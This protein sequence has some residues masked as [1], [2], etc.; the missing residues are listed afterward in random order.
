M[1]QTVILMNMLRSLAT[2]AALSCL[3]LT[4]PAA[5][6][7][8][9]GS[10]Y[11]YTPEWELPL[12]LGVAA[13]AVLLPRLL[14]PARLP[15]PPCGRC[16]PSQ[17]WLGLDRG[18]V[19]NYSPGAALASDV[20][21]VSLISGALTIGLLDVAF[22]EERDQGGQW[23]Q[24]M[25]VASE[26][27]AATLVL[28]QAV[29]YLARRPRP[30]AYN[31]AVPLSVR[32]TRGARLSFF[33]GH[34]SMAFASAGVISTTY[35]LRNPDNRTGQGVVLG[36]T[37]AAAATTAYLRVRAGKHFWTD[38][39]AGALVGG[40]LGVLIPLAHATGEPTD[41]RGCCGARA[42]PLVGGIF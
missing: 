34:S 30:L 25:G 9:A 38:V 17:I 37:L 19:H 2:L 15:A 35:W 3:L 28:T 42:T 24:D 26:A 6:R 23:M 32:A 4:V 5:A 14:H 13:P 39:L 41:E 36:L 11:R 33:S 22:A 40:A 29:K 20:L 1:T 31:P 16:D 10:P 27:L 18:V 21:L 12:T 7:S 8:P